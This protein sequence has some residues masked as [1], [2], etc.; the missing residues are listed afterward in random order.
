MVPGP[1]YVV[2][3][4]TRVPGPN[5]VYPPRGSLDQ[6]TSS[7]PPRGSLD[8][9]YVVICTTMV[10][11]PNYVVI[12]TTRVPGPNYVVISTTR[13][14]G[15]NYV[16]IS[17][18]RVPGPNY[19][20]PPRGSLDQ[21]TYIHHEGPWNKLRRHIHHEGPW[22]KLRRHIHHEGPWTKLRISTTRVPG[23]NYVVISTTKVPGP[24]DVFIQIYFRAIG[25]KNSKNNVSCNFHNKFQTSKMLKRYCVYF[26][27]KSWIFWRFGYF[28]ALANALLMSQVINSLTV[29][30]H[31]RLCN[32]EDENKTFVASL[33][34][35]LD[36]SVCVIANVSTGSFPIL[37]IENR[38]IIQ[39]NT[40]NGITFLWKVKDTKINRHNFTLHIRNVTV[41]DY[42]QSTVY[43]LTAL[44][45]GLDFTFTVNPPGKFKINFTV[46]P[47]DDEELACFVNWYPKLIE[48]RNALQGHQMITFNNSVY[49][50]ENKTLT[51][52][53]PNVGSCEDNSIYTCSVTDFK[54]KTHQRNHTQTSSKYRI[55]S[56]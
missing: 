54:N 33:H 18:T 38:W 28:N 1:N 41:F 39:N 23:P 50:L 40:Y 45:L 12:S 51:I 47:K 42:G 31:P 46:S 9:N 7:Y 22:T 55:S 13:V 56:E 17:T 37:K 3:S 25:K 19:V 44:R 29:S 14:P 21:I 48:I 4:T 16:V 36:I 2:I 5:Y 53:S 30:E 15:P 27:K 11:G 6:I 34:T 43:L 35:P 10:P 8:P 52:T 20:Y 32:I 24:N 26:E 49:Q